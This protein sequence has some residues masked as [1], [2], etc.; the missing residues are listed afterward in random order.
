MITRGVQHRAP[1][2]DCA[3][4]V[5][6]LSDVLDEVPPGPLA[7]AVRR[8]LASCEDCAEQLAWLRAVV[9]ALHALRPEPPPATT[10]AA[11][12]RMFRAWAASR[13]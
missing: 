13:G 1:E 10:R 7:E 4:V 12:L 3:Q 9:A 2:L 11:L 6:L 8:H 5:E